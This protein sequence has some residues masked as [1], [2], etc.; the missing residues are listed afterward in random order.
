MESKQVGFLFV[1]SMEIHMSRMRIW[2]TLTS[3]TIDMHMSRAGQDILLTG[4]TIKIYMTR[5]VLDP[6]KQFNHGDLY[7]MKVS[8]YH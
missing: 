3:L 8:G 6:I 7:V 1:W 4:L 5:E 2:V